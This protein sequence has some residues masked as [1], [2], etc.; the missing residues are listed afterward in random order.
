[1]L[2]VSSAFALGRQDDAEQLYCNIDVAR[3]LQAEWNM[4]VCLQSQ[5]EGRLRACNLEFEW[6]A[7]SLI[8]R[9]RA[10]EAALPDSKPRASTFFF[11]ARDAAIS[12]DYFGH[13][14]GEQFEKS[15][16][17]WCM[18]L[19]DSCLSLL[20]SSRSCCCVSVAT[21]KILHGCLP[22]AATCPR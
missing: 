1:M 8:F 6:F 16:W 11:T 15:T 4:R 18:K 19:A 20:D 12:N 13:L 7:R 22:I 17:N 9:D 3:R 21:W 10:L 14:F 5:A 2:A